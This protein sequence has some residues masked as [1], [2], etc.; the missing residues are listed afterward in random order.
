[1]RYFVFP[2]LGALLVSTLVA[3]DETV[4]FTLTTHW[5][6][7]C[8]FTVPPV[9][10]LD[11]FTKDCLK[12]GYIQVDPKYQGFDNW[13]PSDWSEAT[14]NKAAQVFEDACNNRRGQLNVVQQ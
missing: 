8:V 14:I 12:T 13:V 10:V 11:F 4:T 5:H 7:Y 1:M 6:R 3:A 9:D 2:V